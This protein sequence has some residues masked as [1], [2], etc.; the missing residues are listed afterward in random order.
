MRSSTCPSC[1][2]AVSWTRPAVE[3]FTALLAAPGPPPLPV[4]YP[5]SELNLAAART[6]EDADVARGAALA[7]ARIC[8]QIAVELDPKREAGAVRTLAGHALEL[9]TEFDLES[10]DPQLVA[11]LHLQAG[12]PDMSAPGPTD[13]PIPRGLAHFLA[14][15]RIKRAL[16]DADLPR[17][18][19]IMVRRGTLPDDQHP[20]AASA[21]A[22]RSASAWRARSRS[23]RAVGDAAALRSAR[24]ELLRVSLEAHELDTADDTASALAADAGLDDA[25]RRE[26]ALA[27]A[28]LRSQQ[29]RPADALAALG[30]AAIRDED[31]RWR[32]AET[33]RGNSLRLAGDLPG[34]EAVFAR[35]AERVAADS[36]AEPTDVGLRSAHA[37]ALTHLGMLAVEQGRIGEGEARYAEVD[38]L[39]ADGFL[40]DVP[41]L[42]F[43]SLAAR[44]LLLAG[45]WDQAR[46]RLSAALELRTRL[47]RE[48]GDA[49][50]RERFLVTWAALDERQAALLLRDG[51]GAAALAAIEDAKSRVLRQLARVRAPSRLAPDAADERLRLGWA[52]ADADFRARRVELEAMGIGEPGRPALAAEV[53]RLGRH[54]EAL[55]DAARAQGGRG[56]RARSPARG[57]DHGRR[58]RRG[59]HG[60]GRRERGL[61]GRLVLRLGRRSR[62]LR[63]HRWPGGGEWLDSPTYGELRDGILDGLGRRREALAAGKGTV[64]AWETALA[65]ALGDLHRRPDRSGRADPAAPQDAAAAG[66]PAPRAALGAVRGA[67]R[68][69]IRGRGDR[70]LPGRRGRAGSAARRR[71]PAP[72]ATAGGRARRGAP[73]AR[74]RR[75]AHRRRSAR[76]ARG[77][78]RRRG[79]AAG[80]GGRAL[81][82]ALR[83]GSG[84]PR[85]APRLPRHLGP[86]R[87]GSQRTAP[88]YPI[89][90]ARHRCSAPP[91]G[92]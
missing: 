8:L 78:G 56:D 36:A 61:V 47:E 34:S 92:S 63:G 24:L 10:L 58:G 29:I 25:Q 89:R 77:V 39:F 4:R 3:Q 42:E 51:D 40:L 67:R 46:A 71:R 62:R 6:L 23:S 37:H 85:P 53:G 69:Q 28:D 48:M 50:A 20:P 68:R 2:R 11:D 66:G 86:D 7:R 5:V 73:G 22:R 49:A 83:R 79:H 84:R 16:G 30:R 75:A 19:Q 18:E 1:A 41:R 64:A 52:R 81:R 87:A 35:V 91:E 31:P 17:L 43:L 82:G 44:S 72:C 59:A 80:R 70:P 74:R 65:A 9:A 12:N 60:R 38:A 55:P 90:P 13:I 32:Y 14:A 27:T 54:A 33:I 88:C 45:A 21:I 57:S 76:R 15:H 26:L